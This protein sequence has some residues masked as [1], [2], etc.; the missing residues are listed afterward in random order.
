MSK[1]SG[2]TWV[3]LTVEDGLLSNRVQGVAVSADGFAIYV[4]T[5]KGFSLIINDERAKNPPPERMAQ[6]IKDESFEIEQTFEG[7]R[8][9]P[10]PL[11][12]KKP[13]T[14]SVP[15]KWQLS[16]NRSGFSVVRFNRVAH[17]NNGL[18]NANIRS[19]YARK[20]GA[21]AHIYAVTPTGLF[22]CQDEGFLWAKRQETTNLSEVFLTPN[23][24]RI[25]LIA[26]QNLMISTDFGLSFRRFSLERAFNK[27]QASEDGQT[28]YGLSDGK[29]FK[30][31]GSQAFEKQVFK[32]K[33][34]IFKRGEIRSYMHYRSNDGSESR[35]DDR[36]I[37][38]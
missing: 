12:A 1:D 17:G 19:I 26:A 4:A 21:I 20:V 2:K 28:I 31:I 30:S 33:E 8:V 37:D 32:M 18:K 24:Q 11:I 15:K 6:A 3:T 13:Q 29:L 14:K 35:S 25:F 36:K 27:I 22:H 5:D 38:K 9:I 7:F 16:K 10:K 34:P 23:G